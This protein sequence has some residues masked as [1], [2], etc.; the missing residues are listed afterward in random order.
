M[1]KAIVIFLSLFLMCCLSQEGNV[2][3]NPEGVNVGVLKVAIDTN[4]KPFAYYEDGE[5][6]GFEV[7]LVRE[8]G[9]RMNVRVEF[10]TTTWNDLIPSVLNGKCNCACCVMTE[11]RRVFV[12][13]TDP[14]LET[15]QVLLSK[16]G[17]KEIDGKRVGVLRGSDGQ[18]LALTLGNSGVKF[19]LRVFDSL[20]SALSSLDR[21][22]I[23][24]LIIDNY[25]APKGYKTVGKY[26][27]QVYAF[28]VKDEKIAE[29]INTT[30]KSIKE[31]GTYDRIYEKWFGK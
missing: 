14:Y 30:L 28:A 7:D 8:I 15:W 27:V 13:F 20:D 25:L 17:L 16:E 18:S 3:E 31:D 5:L 21:G 2:G 10:V 24:V 19:D 26:N 9:K 6:K 29:A 1:R 4:H 11:E 22:E 23:D 12:N